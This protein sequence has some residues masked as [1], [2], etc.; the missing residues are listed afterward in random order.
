MLPRRKQQ[1]LAQMRHVLGKYE[2]QALAQR[3]A[4]QGQLMGQLLHLLD[5]R[6]SDASTD[7]GRL[8]E[9]WL[10]LVQPRWYQ[11]LGR[12]RRRLRPLLLKDITKNLVEIPLPTEQLRTLAAADFRIPPLDVRIVALIIGVADAH[13]HAAIAP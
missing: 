10:D 4:T 6:T 9:S 8:A 1:A 2:R 7:L 12:P 11:Q 3:D 5:W 13:R